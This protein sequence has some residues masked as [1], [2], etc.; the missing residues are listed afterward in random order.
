MPSDNNTPYTLF[1]K[2][3][4]SSKENHG[5]KIHENPMSFHRFFIPFS[6]SIFP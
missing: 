2:Y 1:H 4:L 5:S 6:L 3:Y